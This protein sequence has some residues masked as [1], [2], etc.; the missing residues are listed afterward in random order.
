MYKPKIPF[1]SVSDRDWTDWRWQQRNSITDL[2]SIAGFFPRIE[3]AFFLGLKEKA[4]NLKFKI[5]PYILSQISPKCAEQQLLASPWFLQFFPMGEIYKEGHDAYN[6]TDNWEFSHEFPTSLI[7]HKYPD[8]VITRFPE[9]F[10]CCNF[11]FEALRTLEKKSGKKSMMGDWEKSLDYL[12]AHPEVEEF[13]FSGG[14]PLVLPDEVLERMLKNLSEIKA[15]RLKRIHTR[16]L[17]HNPFRMT[18]SLLE[19]LEKYRVNAIALHVAHP[20]E[21]TP[22]FKSAV[23]R[24][25]SKTSVLLVSQTPL[26]KG[27][28]DKTETLQELFLSLYENNIKPYYLFHSLPHTP[29]ADRQR[30]SV[31]KGLML[32]KPLKRHISNI[33]VPEYVLV[34]YTGK[35][36]VPLEINGTPEF[37]YRKDSFGNPV[38]RFLNWKGQLV[39]YPDAR[40]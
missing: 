17:S 10:S 33:A 15:I 26:L 27:V 28:N 13:I 40:E 38:V 9:C 7:Q 39:E 16:V 30:V 20:S 21:I 18:D 24:I 19:I 2:E 11:C 6:G 5:T 32:F 12:K 23:K 8:R 22:E 35:K 36:T 3:P 1:G 14:E 34:H 31:R 25:H 37:Q 4:P 29:Y